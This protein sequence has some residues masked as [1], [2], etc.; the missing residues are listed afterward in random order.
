MDLILFKINKIL[1]ISISFMLL[2]LIVIP[3]TF[4]YENDT[5][6]SLDEDGLVALEDINDNEVLGTSY[7]YYFNASLDN[8]DGDGSKENP[9]K[10]LKAD[11]IMAHANVYLADGEYELDS[12]KSIQE[13]NIVGHDSSKTVIKYD[14][15]AFT[16]WNSLT[17]TNLTVSGATIVNYRNFNATNTIFTYGYGNMVDNYGNTFG[18]A[19]CCPYYDDSYLPT[20]NIRNSTFTQNCAEYAGAIYMDGGGLNIYDSQFLDNLAYNFGGSIACEYGTKVFISKS[21]FFNSRS[22]EDAGGAIYIKDSILRAENVEIINSSATFGGA[23]TTL[24]SDV[25]LTRLTAHNN[26]AKWDGGAIFHMY[27]NFSSLSGDFKNNSANSGG[28]LFIDNSTNLILRQNVFTNNTARYCAGAVYSI[29][30][31]LMGSSSVKQWNIFIGNTAVV[32][33]DAYEMPSINLNIGNGNYEMYKVNFTEITDLPAY[34]SLR[35]YNLITVPKDQLSSGSCWAFTALAVLE[36]AILKAS[37]NYFDFSEENMKNVMARFSDYGWTIN[38]NDGGFDPMP[39]GYLTSWLGPVNE[40]DD[41]YDDKGV[42]SPIFNST[43]HVQNVLYLSRDNFT[44]ND[45]IKRAI[46]NYGAVGTSMLYDNNFF[47]GNGYYCWYSS[48]SNH[49]V[50]IVGWDDNYSRDNFYGLSEDKGDGAWIVRNSWGPYWK[51]Q[52]YFYVSYY[53]EKFAQPGVNNVAYAII[54]NDTIRYDKNYQYDISGRTNYYYTDSSE[55]WYKNIF[56]AADNEFLA[57]ISTYFEKITNWTASVYVNG[58]IRAIK[59]GISNPGYYTFNLDELIPLKIGDVFEVAFKVRG[60]DLTSIPISMKNFLNKLIYKPGIS[61]YS[62]DGENWSDFNDYAGNYAF[63]NYDSQVACIKAFTILRNMSTALYLNVNEDNITA[64]VFDAYGNLLNE[65]NVI[66][67]INGVD[68]DVDLENGLAVLFNPLFNQSYNVISAVFNHEDYDSSSNATSFE[69]AKTEIDLSLNIKR[70][71]NNVNITL[72]SSKSINGSL[73]VIIN[74]DSYS[75]DFKD[76]FATLKLYGLENGVYNIEINDY[77]SLYAFNRIADSFVVDIRKTKIISADLI[78]NENSGDL[79]NITLLD[80]DDEAL[81]QK[82]IVI[83]LDGSTLTKMTDS[84]GMVSIPIDLIEGTYS[85]E[86]RFNGDSD[87]VKINRTNTIKVKSNISI[88]FSISKSLN[89]VLININLSKMVNESLTVEVGNKSYSLRTVNGMASLNLSNLAN[90]YY[91]VKISLDND[92]NISSQ[93]VESDFVMDVKKTSILADDLVLCEGET[94]NFNVTL[95]DENNASLANKKIIFVLNGNMYSRMTDEYGRA[96]L[97]I[98]LESGQYDIVIAFEGDDDFFNSIKTQSIKVKSNIIIYNSLKIFLNKAFMGISLSKPVNES[99][100][101][102]IG[103]MSYSLKTIDGMASLNLSDLS[104]GIYPVAISLDNQNDY[105]SSAF[106]FNFTINAKMTEIIS[107]DL[108]VLDD[109]SN[110]FT[111]ALVDEDGFAVSNKTVFFDLNGKIYNQTTDANGMAAISF[112]LSSGRYLIDVSFEGDD[113]YFKSNRTNSITIK[114][115][116]T[117][118][119]QVIDSRFVKIS[120]SKNIDATLCVVI[121]GNAQMIAVNGTSTSFNLPELDAGNY[122]VTVYIIEN[123]R[124]EFNKAVCP[125]TV[126]VKNTSIILNEMVTYYQSEAKFIVTLIDDEANLLSDKLIEVNISGKIFSK[127]TNE[128]GQVIINVN[129]T[130]GE[131]YVDAI[132]GGDKNYYSSRNSSGISVKSTIIAVD[133]Q[134]KTYGSDY[135]FELLNIDGNPLKNTLVSYIFNNVVYNEITDEGGRVHVKITQRE[136]IYS[137]TIENPVNGESVSKTIHVVKRVAQNRDMII[138]AFSDVPYSVLILNDNGNPVGANEIV[139]FNIAGKTYNVKTDNAGCAFLKISLKANKYSITVSYKGYS[140]SNKITVKPV[141]T[142]KNISKKKA[143]SYRFSAKLVDK[144][145]KPLKGKK[146][147]FKIKGKKYVAKTNKR[148]IAKITIKLSLKVGCYKIYSFYG[149]S[150]IVNRIK[151]RK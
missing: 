127:R 78:T 86:I 144:N 30:N 12:P 53:D 143:K 63:Y 93:S 132:F 100:T 49:A 1:W 136:G 88:D 75:V 65:G 6:V 36:S 52:G 68:Y 149:K 50:T 17:L 28:A 150:K 80:E 9:Y 138:Y 58:E 18:G 134:T 42:L 101:V 60:N 7:D 27:G 124:Y 97:P 45:A 39:I 8:D 25:S 90:G 105:S 20:V 117:I 73:N 59:E 81:C 96:Y 151:I 46:L 131:Y 44:D 135:A 130:N 102:V 147:T 76:G 64:K 109:V 133:S 123:D 146:V 19:I 99:L 31:S 148:G 142:A 128:N 126:A 114:T 140:V 137:L 89:N 110:E 122:N 111:I 107:N 103:N 91:P 35:D 11:R 79:F 72:E 16:V 62:F 4:A 29:C 74:N 66:F 3:S 2:L 120:L 118:S 69:I 57:A 139:Q 125:F 40:L 33:K 61:F 77:L 48:S 145:G 37:G 22:M 21:R 71:F 141:L 54:L 51:D 55:V 41:A 82:D 14:G 70:F 32:N 85:I 104:N 26:S 115:N 95:I 108:V 92:E 47:K 24:N 119:A 129:L 56:N 5:A 113:R 94:V 84:N 43:M 67:S 34:Y 112:D 121:N 106:N 116:V 98:V 83:V 10:Y 15:I 87:Y 13:V 23:I 38:T